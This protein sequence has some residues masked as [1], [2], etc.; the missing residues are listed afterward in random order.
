MLSTTRLDELPVGT[1]L[2]NK[3]GTTT[4]IGYLD[5]EKV[6]RHYKTLDSIS[7]WYSISRLS[8]DE[9]Y[10]QTDEKIIYPYGY[11]TPLWKVL[12]GE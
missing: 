11:N 2:I 5:G 10:V 7:S 8:I 3:V 6:W 9:G 1:K 12:N 4:E